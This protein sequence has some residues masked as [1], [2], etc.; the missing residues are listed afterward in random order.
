[1]SKQTDTLENFTINGNLSVLSGGN[2]NLGYGDIEC[3]GTVFVDTI[4]ENTTG[5]GVNIE[6]ITYENSYFTIPNITAP[7]NPSVSNTRFYVENDIFKSVGNSG[8][9]KTYNPLSNKGD[10]LSHSGTTDITLPVGTNN[11]IFIAD[12]TQATGNKW[13]SIDLVLP[14]TTKGDLI[15]YST[16]NARL[17]VG[18]N[19][20]ILVA[21]S[22]K[23]TGVKWANIGSNVLDSTT[24]SDQNILDT[25]STNSLLL[26]VIYQNLTFEE[27]REYNTVTYNHDILNTPELITILSAGTYIINCR[28]TISGDL[29]GTSVSDVK[30]KIQ[31]SIS[32]GAFTDLVAASNTS[33]VYSSISGCNT[34]NISYIKTYGS[35]DVIKVQAAVLSGNTVV[36]VHP[37]GCSFTAIKTAVDGSLYDT[38]NY[39]NTYNTSNVTLTGTYADIPFNTNRIIGS[40]FSHNS[41]S[42]SI[43]LNDTG[44]YFVVCTFGI[45]KSSGLVRSLAELQLTLNGSVIPG[46]YSGVYSHGTLQY[47]NS[48]FITIAR[49][50]TSGDILKLQGRIGSGINLQLTSE[51]TSLCIMKFQSSSNAQTNVKMFSASDTTG[52]TSIGTSYADVPLITEAIKDSIYTHTASNYAV[53][54]NEDGYYYVFGRVTCTN[55]ITDT[56]GDEAY[57]QIRLLLNRGSGYFEVDGTISQALHANTSAGTGT[58][59]F[60]CVLYLQSGSLLKMQAI[61]FAKNG[62]G[63]LI[64]YA[65]GSNLDIIKLSATN[66][67]VSS[68]LDFGSY[69]KEIKETIGTSTTS[70]IFIPKIDLV[71]DIIPSGKYIIWYSVIVNGPSSNITVYE[72]QV[73]LNST[74]ILY[75]SLTK[76][77]QSVTH[78]TVT[79]FSN[80]ELLQGSHII[81]IN[82]RAVNGVDQVVVSDAK[83]MIWRISN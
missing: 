21:D 39:L 63:N 12:S 26:T 7:S 11:Q 75:K 74:I 29:A 44:K 80:V 65:N 13:G 70:S 1:M 40:S 23:A 27:N 38:S 6:G 66:S 60:I 36:T 35:G 61:K 34:C 16:T 48:G 9:V 14:A 5:I 17:P 64:L 76:I 51:M 67:L 68:I 77:Y 33:V 18:T 41:G 55:T 81:T 72:I 52:G 24:I 56:M 83:L 19:N 47:H 10:I 82:Y 78:Y 22:T 69:F 73:T 3:E 20:Q 71:T 46:T 58:A 42:S 54:V 59:N 4:S 49:S 2:A 37:Y 15:V 28:I 32:S 45:N 30:V 53:T 25:Y 43:T 31:E 62:N 8:I 50:F 79:S 57:S